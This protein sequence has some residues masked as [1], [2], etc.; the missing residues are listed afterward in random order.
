MGERNIVLF[1][2]MPG[3]EPDRDAGYAAGAFRTLERISARMHGHARAWSRLGRF[4]RPH[5]D[6]ART[7][8]ADGHWGRWQAGLGMGREERAL[9]D[10]L[11]AVI[12]ARLERYGAG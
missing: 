12:A 11:D 8:G 2:W 10:R 7:L 1:D 3:A 4:R 6:Y 5:W 9:L